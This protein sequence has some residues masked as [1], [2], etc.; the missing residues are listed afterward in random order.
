MKNETK[1]DEKKDEKDSG[2]RIGSRM[3]EKEH[4]SYTP[5]PL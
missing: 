2:C 5:L 4:S 1:K 3:D